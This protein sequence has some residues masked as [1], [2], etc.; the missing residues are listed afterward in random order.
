GAWLNAKRMQAEGNFRNLFNSVNDSVFVH[1]ARTGK[2]MDVNE[3]AARMF[4]AP[5]Q[6]LLAMDFKLSSADTEEYSVAKAFEKIRLAA[7]QGPQVF[8]WLSRRVDDGRLFPTE[9]ALRQ[10]I[11]D[12]QPVVLA[13]VRDISLRKK[14]EEAARESEQRLQMFNDL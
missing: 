7:T 1:D 12:N 14:A 6:E 2:V 10:E 4:G 11:I 5:R 3:T 13:S 8:E 9:V